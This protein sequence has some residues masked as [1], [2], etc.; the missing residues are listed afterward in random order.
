MFRNG[1]DTCRVFQRSVSVVSLEEEMVLE[2]AK[3][4]TR[5]VLNRGRRS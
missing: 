2:V 1:Y 3:E 5:K 4:E